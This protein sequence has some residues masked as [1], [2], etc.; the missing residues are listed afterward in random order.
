[1]RHAAVDESAK[2]RIAAMDIADRIGEEG[3]HQARLVQNGR[4]FLWY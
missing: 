4:R 3:G 1:M 2:L